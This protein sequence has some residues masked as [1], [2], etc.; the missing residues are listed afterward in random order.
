[1]KRVILDA[2][3]LINF[4]SDQED[5]KKE[6]EKIFDDLENRDLIIFVP[7]LALYE[8]IYNLKKQN[9]V[10]T[11]VEFLKQFI[12]SPDVF[13]YKMDNSEFVEISNTSVENNLSTYDAIYL[14]LSLAT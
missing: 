2:N 14:Y 12:A 13:T 6:V 5:T 1:M 11:L 3:I 8:L 4:C 9:Q 7:D 10:Q